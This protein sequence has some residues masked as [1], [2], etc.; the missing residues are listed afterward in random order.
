MRFATP[1]ALFAA[2]AVAQE[3]STVIEKVTSTTKQI[4]TVTQCHSTYTDCPLSSTS[5]AVATFSEVASTSE[6]AS[7]SEVVT[8]SIVTPSSAVTPTSAVTSSATQPAGNATAVHPTGVIP[9]TTTGATVVPTGA[10]VRLQSGAMA[11][12]AAALVA[13]AL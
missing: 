2:L 3:D 1:L 8:P 7:P 4:V 13:L 12:A 9:S 6:V 10:A 5:S 11:V